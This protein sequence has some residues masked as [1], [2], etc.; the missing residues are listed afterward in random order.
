MSKIH[1]ATDIETKPLQYDEA[2]HHGS[3]KDHAP[4]EHRKSRL[5]RLV[6]AGDL[7]LAFSII[8]FPMLAVPFVLLGLVTWGK[9]DFPNNG[10]EA[11]PIDD[12]VP[13]GNYYTVVSSGKFA[14]ISSWAST[15]VGNVSAPFLILFSFF[16]ARSLAQRQESHVGM[17]T[18]DEG[19]NMSPESQIRQILHSRTFAKLWRW[20]R[21]LLPWGSR[22]FT[23]DG[24]TFVAIVGLGLTLLFTYVDF[25]A[26]SARES[27]LLIADRALVIVGGMTLTSVESWS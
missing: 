20:I 13:T 26:K 2:G 12:P 1:S 16:I 5:T 22:K 24:A 4:K 9:V 8:F 23:A 11:L 21:S 18:G 10:T 14:L 17:S 27:E 19:H 7:C 25:H 15:V 6:S 3:T